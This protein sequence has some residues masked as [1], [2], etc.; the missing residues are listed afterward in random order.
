MIRALPS[1][2]ILR[3]LA[4]STL[5]IWVAMHLMVMVLGATDG[6]DFSF[7]PSSIV[8][9]YL[10][11]LVPVL[12]FFQLR[13]SRY[14]IFLANLGVSRRFALG[15]GLVV[16]VALELSADALLRLFLSA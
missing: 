8:S 11:L 13:V 5:E 4:G 7:W 10:V 3:S 16:A 15:L 6:G 2:F 9:V 1:L 12:L 14:R